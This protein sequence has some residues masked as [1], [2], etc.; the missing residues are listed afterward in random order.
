MKHA[1]NPSD[2]LLEEDHL[3]FDIPRQ[4]QLTNMSLAMQTLYACMNA[5]SSMPRFGVFY[6]NSG[7]GKTVAAAFAASVTDAAYIEARSIWTVKT[8]LRALAIA[9]GIAAPAKTAADLLEQIIA[10]L[11]AQPRP[12]IIDEMDHLVKKQA[13]DIL[14]DIH[15]ATSVAILMIGEEALPSKLKEWERFDNRILESTPAQ[16]ASKD[17]VLKLRD[18][19]C[20]RVN[21]AD[22]L[23]LHIGAVCRFVTRRVVTNLKRVQDTA[24]QA[25]INTADLAWW[26]NRAIINGDLLT[27]RSA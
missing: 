6:G 5:G 1:L 26:G 8:F 18:Y 12:L 9:L 13:V 4:A 16:P 17:D 21:V 24:L 27:R 15:D 7:Y 11:N 10:S 19:Y 25:G 14:R 20:G 3:A 23:A 2:A 22:D